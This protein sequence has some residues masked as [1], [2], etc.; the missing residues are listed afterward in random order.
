MV[1]F[2]SA[3]VE[4]AATFS[5]TAVR[6]P[7]ASYANSDRRPSGATVAAVRPASSYSTVETGTSSDGAGGADGRARAPPPLV[8]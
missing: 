4:P 3:S 2:A 7:R 6:R 1:R 8:P 5:T